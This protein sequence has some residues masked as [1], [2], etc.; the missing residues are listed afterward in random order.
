MI[1]LLGLVIGTLSL[2]GIAIGDSISK[3]IAKPKDIA[4]RNY[5]YMYHE[6]NYLTHEDVTQRINFYKL[7]V[8]LVLAQST[9][10]Y[11][12]SAQIRPQPV[13]YQIRQNTEK[14]ELVK[15]KNSTSQI[16]GSQLSSPTGPSKPV[17]GNGNGPGNDP[18]KSNRPKTPKS[19]VSKP[20]IFGI[21]R[22]GNSIDPYSESEQ[23]KLLKVAQSEYQ[24]LLRGDYG[25]LEYFNCTKKRFLDLCR[26]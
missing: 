25:H 1:N 2:A 15:G 26:K 5:P 22:L 8:V 14:V 12:D 6:Q 18:T 23:Q 10:T 21:P 9:V 16:Y 11:R 19:G 4:R 7:P 20:S 17:G 3:K 24:K 13:A